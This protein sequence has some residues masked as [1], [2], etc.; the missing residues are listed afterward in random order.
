MYKNSVNLLIMNSKQ[1]GHVVQ[2]RVCRKCDSIFSFSFSARTNDV[3][4]TKKFYI[5]RGDSNFQTMA[6]VHAKLASLGK[7]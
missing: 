7:R 5:C 6:F 3:L 4:L 1:L 2:I